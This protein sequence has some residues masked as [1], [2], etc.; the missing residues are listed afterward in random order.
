MPGEAGTMKR[1]DGTCLQ[2][3][4]PSPSDFVVKAF[5][6][7]GGACWFVLT[8]RWTLIRTELEKKFGL[9]SIATTRPAVH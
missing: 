8:G 3:G 1:V 4:G 2:E 5:A 6:I 7:V 9:I